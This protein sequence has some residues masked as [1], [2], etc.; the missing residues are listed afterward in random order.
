MRPPP[1]DADGCVKPHDH[2]QTQDEDIMLRGISE[3]WIKFTS[4]GKR[5]ISSGAFH[6]SRD[7]YGGLSLEAKK[8][9]ECLERTTE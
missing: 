4:D 8:V 5:R 6:P 3:Y 7:K 1:R 9:L 2:D